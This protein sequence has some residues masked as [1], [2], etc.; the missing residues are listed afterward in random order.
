MIKRN[1][2]GVTAF[3]FLYED[4]LVNE[5]KNGK[6]QWKSDQKAPSDLLFMTERNLPDDP[7][8]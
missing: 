8:Q 4:S 7:G 6:R 3:L 2:V 5:Q 1:A